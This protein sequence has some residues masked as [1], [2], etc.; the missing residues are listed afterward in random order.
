MKIKNEGFTEFPNSPNFLSPK[1]NRI[2]VVK[3]NRWRTKCSPPTRLHDVT[4]TTN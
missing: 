1:S 2:N 3:K 4:P